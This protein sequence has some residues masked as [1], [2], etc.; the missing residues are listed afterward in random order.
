MMPG[1]LYGI[2]YISSSN[3]LGL[4]TC[5]NPKNNP[6]IIMKRLFVLNIFR[7][8]SLNTNSSNSGANRIVKIV[9]N[10]GAFLKV[11]TIIS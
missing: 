3:E 2:I 9:V 11:S 5:I 4:E 6:D 10:I 8:D 7:K 1:I